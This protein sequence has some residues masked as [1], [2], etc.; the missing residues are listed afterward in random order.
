MLLIEDDVMAIA[1]QAPTPANEVLD[2]LLSQPTPAQILG[3]HASDATQTRVRYLLDSNRNDQLKDAEKA[4]LEA[5][6]QVEH[7]VRR[8]KIRARERQLETA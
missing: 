4:E 1:T 8:L 2:F 6:L 5:Y 3:F 7:F